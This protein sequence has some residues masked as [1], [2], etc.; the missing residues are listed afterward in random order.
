MRQ[1]DLAKINYSVENLVKKESEETPAIHIDLTQ[2]VPTSNALSAPYAVPSPQAIQHPSGDTA[3]LISANSC[4]PYDVPP[5]IPLSYSTVYGQ[6]GGDN[7]L[8]IDE[9][10]DN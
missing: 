4:K 10:Y 3:H 8:Y 2:V 5:L 6:S 1:P 7:S 9:D